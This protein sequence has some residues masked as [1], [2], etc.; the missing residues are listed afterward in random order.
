LGGN[1]LGDLELKGVSY[2]YADGTVAL[3]NVSWSI[4]NGQKVAILGPNGAGKSTL[5]KIVAGLLFPDTGS[6]LV[7][8]V[9]LNK[10]NAD[11]LRRKMGVLFQDPDDQIFMPRVWD[12]VAFGP[13][14]LEL[15]SDRVTELVE[16]A[17][18]AVHMQGHEDR[19]PH[20]MSYGE[21]KRV[22]IA[23]ILAMEPDI[24]LLDEPTSNLDPGGRRELIE[25]LG[26][27]DK[28]LIVA[29]HDVNAGTLLADRALVLNKK[30]LA[31]GSLREIFS[32]KHLLE[33]ANLDL[34][35]VAKLFLHLMKNGASF[36]RLPLSV[37][38]G[39]KELLDLLGSG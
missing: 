2:S 6:V 16:S 27:L 33:E 25:I 29:T 10:K 31:E 11:I 32:R 5:L 17:L 30:K 24:L 7:D 34:P 19:V 38:E 14:N 12:D 35:D 15:P 8:G 1:A 3:R 4:G 13:T 36:D 39:S 22:A 28:T 26:G 18:R 23:G 20:H 21:K 37:E 9:E